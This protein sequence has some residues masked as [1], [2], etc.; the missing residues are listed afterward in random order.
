ML[1]TVSG[2]ALP[3]ET[4]AILTLIEEDGELKILHFKDFAGPQER[5]AFITGAAQAAAQRVAV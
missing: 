5:N 1:T 4:V 2:A 3:Y